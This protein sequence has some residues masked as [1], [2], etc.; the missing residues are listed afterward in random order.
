MLD[1]L[2]APTWPAG[3]TGV[4]DRRCGHAGGRGRGLSRGAARRSERE[5]QT[6]E[7]D[8]S[9]VFTGSFAS[10]PV[11]GCADTG[12][13][14]RLRPDGLRHGR[15]HGR[16]RARTSAT[17]TSPTAF[18]LPIVRTVQPPARLG[19]A[20]RTLAKVPPINSERRDHL[21]GL[22]DRR[23]QGEDHRLAG[24]QGPRPTAT[25][26]VPAAGLAVQPTAVLGRA[27]PDRVRRA[28]LPR[29]ACPSRCCRSSC[30]RS[31]TT[32]RGPS[33]R[34]TRLRARSRRWRGRPRWVEVELDLG[35]GPQTTGARRTRCRS[36][37]GSCW[38]E[39]R[40]LDP[41]NDERVRRPRGRAVLD[42]PATPTVRRRRRPVRRRGRAR[43]A[44]PAVRAVLAQGAVRPGPRV[45][46]ASRSAGCSTRA[47]SRRY[48][49]TDARGIY[50]P[51]REVVESDGW[52]F[53]R[54]RS[55]STGS[56]ARWARA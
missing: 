34:T 5:R 41:T 8:K 15:D 9:G 1:A 39:L 20:R 55:R 47:T 12:V 27:V 29:G 31:T 33:T 42:G 50:V 30:P 7:R 6:E 49:Y 52:F 19:R 16:A 51:A 21:D 32:R 45:E 48:A 38:Y 4:L 35:D 26:H 36:G 14:R 40:Y 23:G 37:P 10:N 44:A 46:L 3:T 24:G 13:R 18:E 25:V 54:G 28:R 22:D 2:T 11:N 17:G 53:L 56:S 43:R